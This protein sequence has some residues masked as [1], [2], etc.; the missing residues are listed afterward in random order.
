MQHI[1]VADIMQRHPLTFNTQ[2]S[3]VAAVDLLVE[4][5]VSGGP[6]LNA[7]SQVIGFLSEHDCIR[8]MLMAAYYDE[9]VALVQDVM[10][11]SP[12]TVAP[13]LALEDMAQLIV[14]NTPKLYPVVD[15]DRR[16][17]GVVSRGDVLK[18]LDR[19][20]HSHYKR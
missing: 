2:M 20:L 13:E 12:M 11:T 3:L 1:H 10:K 18:A 8:R 17:L 7:Q 4:R 6:V 14:A 15:D 9:T 19:E 5:G 16:L